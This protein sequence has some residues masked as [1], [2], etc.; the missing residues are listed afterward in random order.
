M[1]NLGTLV[2]KYVMSQKNVL[3]STKGTDTNIHNTSIKN[4][5]VKVLSVT[6]QAGTDRKQRFCCLTLLYNAKTRSTYC[7]G[8]NIYDCQILYCPTNALNYINCR[9]IKN[10]LKCK[11]C[12]DVFRFTQEPSSGSQSQCLAKITGMVPLCLSI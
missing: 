7:N 2:L 12:S 1:E 3:D 10:T 9:V 6:F 11:S 5:K 4:T 8:Q